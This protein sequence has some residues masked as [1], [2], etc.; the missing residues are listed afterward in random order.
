MG[1]QSRLPDSTSFLYTS[2]LD[3]TCGTR[4]RP[5]NPDLALGPVLR[6][7]AGAEARCA[8]RAA[9]C[10]RHRDP[11]HMLCRRCPFSPP[12]PPPPRNSLLSHPLAFPDTPMPSPLIYNVSSVAGF[13]ISKGCMPECGYAAPRRSPS[14]G[15]GCPHPPSSARK[16]VKRKMSE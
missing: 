1:V 2:K 13:C 9:S 8:R 15:P 12:P 10:M 14:A 6:G 5:M 3:S 16:R 7:A 4:W 11:L